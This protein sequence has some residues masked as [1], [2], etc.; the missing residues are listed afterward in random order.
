MVLGANILLLLRG[1]PLA[2][3]STQLCSGPS[4]QKKT[5]MK[6]KKMRDSRKSEAR[7]KTEQQTNQKTQIYALS[8]EDGKAVKNFKFLSMF[9]TI[10]QGR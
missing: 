7:Q 4:I 1:S 2:S 9:S 3:I 5:K 6:K 10:A 8:V